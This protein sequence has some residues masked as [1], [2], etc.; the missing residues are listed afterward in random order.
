MPPL[1]LLARRGGRLG[2]GNVD[3][4]TQREDVV[5]LLVT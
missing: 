2:V 4:I 1:V 5:E 3:G